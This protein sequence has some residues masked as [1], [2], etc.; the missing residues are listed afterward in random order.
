MHEVTIDYWLAVGRHPVT[1]GEWRRYLADTGRT[2]SRNA[3]GFPAGSGTLTQKEEYCWSSPGFAQ[4]D[5]HPAVCVTWHEATDYAVWL[6]TKTRR[7]Y[8]LLSEAEYEYVNRAGRRSVYWWGDSGE[9]VWRYA[10]G[11]DA[12]LK[13]AH[14]Y[15]GWAYAAGNDGFAYT[16]PVGHFPAN[17]FG[18]HDTTGNVWCWVA[19]RWHGSYEGAPTD[20]SAWES[21]TSSSRVARSASWFNDPPELRCAYRGGGSPEESFTFNG[22]RLACT[23]G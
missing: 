19:D 15:S 20:G 4:D 6:S 21:G 2:G 9:E 5:N 16:S 13:A 8:R 11:A 17:P 10:N 3:Y 14:H 22:F 1:R 12:A 23:A 18:L 7:P